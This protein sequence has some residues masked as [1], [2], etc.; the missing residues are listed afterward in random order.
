MS[1][2]KD[3]PIKFAAK[4]NRA[5]LKSKHIRLGAILLLIISSYYF[6]SDMTGNVK[7]SAKEGED[8]LFEE[9]L[10]NL[11]KVQSFRED[12]DVTGLIDP[13]LINEI[14]NEFKRINGAGGIP[15]AS[16]S[17][18]AKCI[19]YIE[20]SQDPHG[21]LSSGHLK[22]PYQRPPKHC[23]T[24][25]S[26][27][28]E[29][30][31]LDLQER[32]DNPDL[33]RLIENAL[34]NTLDTAI[35]WYDTKREPFET[36]ISTGDIHAEWLRDSTRQLSIYQKLTP[37]DQALADMVKGAINLQA[38][39][40][41]NDPY[42]NAF[43]PPKRSDVKKGDSAKDK[44]NPK[45][46]WNNVFEC[47][48]EIDSIASFL[49]LT[50][51]YFEN[52]K[53]ISVFTKDW[54]RA[55]TNVIILIKRESSPTFKDENG[56]VLPFYYSFQRNTDIGTETLPLAGTGNPV[57]FGIGLVRSAF[58]PSDDACIL[59]FFVPGNIQMQYELSAIWEILNSIKDELTIQ[60]PEITAA[61][62]QIL[63][64]DLKKYS[65]I[66]S[67]AIQ[68]HAIVNHPKYGK[69][70]A[71]EVD[72]YGGSIFMD[73]ANIPSLLSIPELTDQTS[74][75]DEIYQNTR[76]MILSKSGNPYY[77]K[78][79]Y[80]K[81]I[82]GPHIGIHNAWPMSLL[83]QIRTSDDDE[84]ILE[85]LELVL[86]T[87]GGLGLIH[88]SINVMIPDGSSYTRPWFSWANSEFGK[89]ILDLAER[90]PHLI[91]KE[92]FKNKPYYIGKDF[93]N[94]LNDE[95]N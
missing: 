33:Y 52:T 95:Q 18:N 25:A 41:V 9:K 7:R 40:I 23:R 15:L 27:A 93:K 4:P 24:F 49:T 21:P 75:S 63:L 19:N 44:V 13:K 64:D 83:V 77:L 78:G 88:E 26:P 55:L 11:Y 74:A 71:Y 60:I 8:A 62:L 43:H 14:T 1:T 92:A 65:D 30:L 47:K 37:Y 6:L 53:D 42:C 45:P 3:K 48:Y 56:Q 86:K 68:T 38:G 17:S 76:K 29:K 31:L 5:L 51:E 20:Y 16:D 28:V 66:I 61:K 79:P 32:I 84:E 94:S 70:Y 81:G 69:V 57:N 39:Y 73:D 50:R 82:G 87:T 80:F 36:F 12:S 58:R 91:F 35:L 10:N 54:F 89:T 67:E 46:N 90:K 59:Q 22:L 85:L 2:F 34:P 72:G